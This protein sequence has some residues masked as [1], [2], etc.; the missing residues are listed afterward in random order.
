MDSFTVNGDLVILA[1]QAIKTDHGIVVQT[2]CPS[3]LSV[4]SASDAYHFAN[5]ILKELDRMGYSG[6]ARS[7]NMTLERL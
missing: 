3:G 5:N 7:E 6:T 1:S 4:L 2:R